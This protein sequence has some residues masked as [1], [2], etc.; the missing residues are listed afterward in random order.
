MDLVKLFKKERPHA[1]HLNS[2]KAG[3][4][5]ALAAR[6]AEI[7]RI[8]F[9][10]H[11]LP[12]DENRN[13]VMRFAIFFATWITFLLCHN[14]ICISEDNA[15]RARMLPFVGRR[16][17][18]IPNGIGDISFID[19]E[20]ARSILLKG[21]GKPQGTL[22]FGTIAELTKNKG[23][24][25][26]LAA[27]QKLK[28]QGLKFSFFI[29]GEG[30]DR[31][32]LEAEV[33]HRGLSEIVYFLGYIPE[34]ERFLKAFDVFVLSSIK[35]GLPYVLLEAGKAGL[36]VV[37]SDIPGIRDIVENGVSG[38]LVSEKNSEALAEALTRMKNP[39]TR[40]RFGTALEKRVKENFF[41][42]R[43]VE[44]TRTLY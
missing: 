41:L 35:E 15:R 21:A 22:W 12:Y 7:P 14:V 43:M 10:V 3:G 24:F 17:R 28:V 30:E 6:I 2:S 34:A 23:L 29:I 19:H 40:E 39:E 16:V 32:L 31:K 38:I 8:V 37:G 42:T 4:V 18:F 25:Y 36:P 11:G 33:R 26:A 13:I 9:T 27:C 5:G 1:V 44:E 20:K